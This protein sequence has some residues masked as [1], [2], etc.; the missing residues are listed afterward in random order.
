MKKYSWLILSLL[1]VACSGEE[2]QDPDIIEPSSPAVSIQSPRNEDQFNIGD[3]LNIQVKVNFPEEAKELKLFIDDTLYQNLE[4]IDQTIKVDTKNGRVGFVNFYLSYVDGSGKLHQDNRQ[5]VFFSDLVP[6]RKKVKILKTFPHDKSSYTQGLEWYKG[7]LFEG[8]GQYGTSVLATVN[9]STGAHKRKYELASSYFGEGITILNDTIYQITY[10][11][12]IC[13]M[14]D[15]EFN[16]IGQFAYEG[17]GW[18]LCNNGKH[19]LMSNGSSEIVWRDPR[20]FAV[21][22]KIQVFEPEK[23]VVSLNELELIN[24]RLYANIYR[25][26][27]VVEIDTTTGK[28]LSYI[29]CKELEKGIIGA[30]VLNGI[31][32]N[33]ATGKTYMTGK[34]W[35][36]LFEVEFE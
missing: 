30:D 33:P 4:T 32:Y 27:T 28:V 12:G 23:D 36:T 18:G 20:T 3:P 9:L 1:M 15:M 2:E 19:I 24:G 6:V 10:T 16:E 25:E 14:Y 29:D 5:V 22:K 21:V 26:N 31:A 13:F 7:E 35:P 34:L 11:S 8:T 17:Q